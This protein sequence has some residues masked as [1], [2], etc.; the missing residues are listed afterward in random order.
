VQPFA[1]C[2]PIR[3][4]RSLTQA[5]LSRRATTD[6]T[7]SARFMAQPRASS[8]PLNRTTYFL[9]AISVPATNHLPCCVAA[10]GIQKHTTSSRTRSTGD[11]ID[12]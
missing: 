6:S 4:A 8:L 5:K 9:T 11:L 1:A 2:R 12:G 3:N 7:Q 10:A